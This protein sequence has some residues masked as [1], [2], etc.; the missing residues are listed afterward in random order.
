MNGFDLKFHHFGL[1]VRAPDSAFV[2]LKSLGYSEGRT[3]YDPLQRV[4]VALCHHNEMPDVEVIWPGDGP[5]PIDNLIKR[6]GSTIYHL[7][8]S[9]DD[10]K[11][12]IAAMKAAGLRVLNVS[13]PKAAVLFGGREVSFYSIADV[14]IIELIHGEPGESTCATGSSV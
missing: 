9:C 8:Y 2:Y 5:S 4:N 6:G 11:G 10:P 13:P 14:G 3:V 7:C 12:A 1:A